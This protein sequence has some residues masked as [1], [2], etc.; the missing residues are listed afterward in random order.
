MLKLDEIKQILIKKYNLQVKPTC[1]VSSFSIMKQLSEK[2]L[3]NPEKVFEIEQNISNGE[4][5]RQ[6]FTDVNSV[7]EFL[8][9]HETDVDR[10]YRI[11]RKEELFLN[12]CLQA[13]GFKNVIIS[14][15]PQT[16]LASFEDAEND[17]DEDDEYK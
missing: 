4:D 16:L 15:D 13:F 5:F 8:L 2:M 12:T 17:L 11:L 1:G 10:F 7:K 9:L 14:L 6:Y 3:E